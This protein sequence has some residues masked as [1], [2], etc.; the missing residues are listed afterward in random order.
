MYL[1]VRDG[2]GR[3]VGVCPGFITESLHIKIYDSTPY[4]DYGGPAI[5]TPYVARASFA[6]L[7]FLRQLSS[8]QGLAF[9]RFLVTEKALARHLGSPIS[10]T[11]SNFGVM[12]I[13][14]TATPSQFI[15][16]HV[17]SKNR[18]QKFNQME[19]K[20]FQV[21]EARTRS[22]L[23][24]FYN[25][26]LRNM[27]HIGARPYPYS[28]M[29]SI[30][31]TLYPSF[32]RI[33]ILENRKPLAANLYFRYAQK[34]F[35][36]YAGIDRNETLVYPLLN[37]LIWTE[38]KKAEEEGLLQLSLGSTPSDPDSMYF[39]QKSSMGSEFHPQT[40]CWHPLSPSGQILIQMRPFAAFAWKTFRGASPKL[41]ERILER[42]LASL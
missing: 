10:H 38:T 22:D 32:V 42:K 28:L 3:L 21:R 16:S 19:R 15:W 4:S 25:L 11:E 29:E 27:M 12:E 1:V 33:W 14:L 6:I 41:L 13:N 30:W 7:D 37:Y 40:I 31:D 17:F 36:A 39:I 34:S 9:A 26:Y 24:V 8:S 35:W 23:Q 18:R 2:G 20:G 5:E